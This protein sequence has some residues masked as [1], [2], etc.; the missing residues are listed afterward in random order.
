MRDRRHSREGTRHAQGRVRVSGRGVR[1]E[2]PGAARAH[3][4]GGADHA[5][6]HRHPAITIDQDT[7]TNVDLPMLQQWMTDATKAMTDGRL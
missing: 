1:L 6:R 7:F 2:G 4:S 3:R 5:R